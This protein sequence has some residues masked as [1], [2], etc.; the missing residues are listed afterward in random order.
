ML[1]IAITFFREGFPN[2]EEYNEEYMAP[3]LLKAVR[4]CAEGAD[5][6]NHLRSKAD[7]HEQIILLEIVA[8]F[9]RYLQAALMKSAPK[10]CIILTSLA[11]TEP[12]H[13]DN[14]A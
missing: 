7:P 10:S 6:M 9:P 2:I 13:N 1:D 3:R 11:K 5:V 12:S 14:L 4:M 8:P